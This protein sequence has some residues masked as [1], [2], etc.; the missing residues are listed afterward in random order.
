M[1]KHAF[2]PEKILIAYFSHTGTT[3]AV[4]KQIQEKI[5]GDLFEIVPVN[6]YPSN[7]NQCVEQAKKELNAQFR[8]E[9]KTKIDDMNGYDLV[10]IGYPNWWGTIPMPI[11]TFLTSY[12]LS[13]ATIAPFC[14]HG[15]GG[16]GRSANDISGLCQD[17]S[18]LDGLAIRSSAV[19]SA[20]DSVA[21]WLKE[22][23]IIE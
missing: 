20:Q 16:I 9:L 23:E 17:S 5:G 3:Q 10:F 21:R 4:A 13:G 14:T 22:Q 15:G 19:S 7:Y 6:P 8:P 2:E 12:D 18:V 11:A 1:G